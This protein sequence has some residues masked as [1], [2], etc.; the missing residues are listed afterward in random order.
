MEGN[1]LL[2]CEAKLIDRMMEQ[3]KFLGFLQKRFNDVKSNM[4]SLEWVL[5][6]GSFEN[7][8]LENEDRSTKH[9]NLEKEAPKTRK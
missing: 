4:E 3:M 9:P 2:M 8:A 7:K 1:L 6:V 5:N